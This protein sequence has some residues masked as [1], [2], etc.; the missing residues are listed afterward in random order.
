MSPALEGS[1]E[2]DAEDLL[3]EPLADDAR[4]EAED[5]R[6]IMLAGRL[7]DE[8]IGAERR[9]HAFIAVCRDAHPDARAA[10][11]DADAL[12]AL[13]SL[14][15]LGCIIGIIDAGLIVGAKIDGLIAMR[16]DLLDELCFERDAC[17]IGGDEE[18]LLTHSCSLKTRLTF[19]PPKPKLF[20]IATR[21]RASLATFGMRSKPSASSTGSSRLIV[22][23][24]RRLTMASVVMTAS[25]A[26][27]AP[28]RCPVMLFVLE[29]RSPRFARSPKTLSIAMS[30]CIS[31]VGVEVPCAFT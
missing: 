25:S 19:V 11:K 13:N 10:D 5:I 14:S 1:L 23:G 20:E 17:M 26:P 12:T 21:T 2:E 15:D 9:P 30:S 7:R 31:P 29:T 8:G 18:L 6:V 3:G 22:G 28:S 16:A 4:S 27:A 24:M